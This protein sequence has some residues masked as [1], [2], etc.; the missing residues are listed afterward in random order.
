MQASNHNSLIHHDDVYSII[1]QLKMEPVM[2][3]KLMAAA[4]D[5]PD[6]VNM[7]GESDYML[8]LSVV[9]CHIVMTTV[10]DNTLKVS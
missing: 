7:S 6:D 10:Y 3:L 5:D 2:Q 4:R 8:N 1:I 9:L